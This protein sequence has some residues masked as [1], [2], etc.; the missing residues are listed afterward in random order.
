M[1]ETREQNVP[2]SSPKK[3]GL[4]L[5]ALLSA[6]VYYLWAMPLGDISLESVAHRCVKGSHHCK[7]SMTVC[8]YPA[9]F[10]TQGIPTQSQTRCLSTQV[11]KHGM[12]AYACLPFHWLGYHGCPRNKFP[13][14]NFTLRIS[15]MLGV[16][17][18]WPQACD[19]ACL[20][21]TPFVG[22]QKDYLCWMGH[23]S[24][25]CN[26]ESLL[27]PFWIPFLN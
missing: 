14:R 7:C 4:E 25:V 9:M 26:D 20:S 27:K 22:C 15:Y 3:S 5:L 19:L 13:D 10:T 16:E 11:E 24:L 18:Y 8:K 12:K 6:G 2:W 21:D 1:H 23:I 17:W